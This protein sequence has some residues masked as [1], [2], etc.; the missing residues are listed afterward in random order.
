MPILALAAAV[1]LNLFGGLLYCWSV[2][3]EPLET[4]LGVDRAAV[5]SVFS[6]GLV[7]Y[8]AGFFITPR[9]LRLG[10]MPI[11]AGGACLVAAGGLALAGFVQSLAAL[12]VGFGLCFALASGF[13]YSLC[14]Q[15]ANAPLPIRASIATGLATSAFAAAGLVWPWLLVRAIEW[16]GPHAAMLYAS[17]AFVVIGAIVAALLA[18]SRVSAP[19]AT[20]ESDIRMFRNFATDRPPIFI[21]MWLGFVFMGLGGLMAIGHSAGIVVAFGLPLKEAYL[22][23]MVVS[24]GYIVGSMTAGVAS[25]LLTG[26][27]VLIGLAAIVA[28][29]LFALRLF[30]GV[31]P[32]LIALAFVAGAFGATATVY[33]VTIVAYYG[34]QQLAPVYGR[35]MLAY[36]VAGLI[37]PWMAG[38]LFDWEKSYSWSLV[39]AGLFA[40]LAVAANHRLPRPERARQN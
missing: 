32:S 18:L 34:V 28:L 11:L 22:G 33:P 14:L 23:P 38:A 13:A 30:P 9:L 8:T 24:L 37:A 20:A 35:I 39:I 4:S 31:N 21:F 27:R 10:G 2:F 15:V 16:Q 6:I 12:I 36:G 3:I 26:R 25:D 5:S 1:L 29:A 40:L 7:A 17:G 19:S